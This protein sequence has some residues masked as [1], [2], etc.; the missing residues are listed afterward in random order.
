M[1]NLVFGNENYVIK[2]GASITGASSLVEWDYFDQLC[3][4]EHGKGNERV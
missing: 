2:T 1:F 3:H 4:E